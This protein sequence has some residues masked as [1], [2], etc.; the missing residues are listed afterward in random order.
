MNKLFLQQLSLISL[1]AS[2]L[3]LAACGGSDT[4]IVERDPIAIED[5]HD[6]H[7]EH[8][9]DDDHNHDHEQ[10]LGRLLIS[11]KDV[12]RVLVLDA[13][14][15]STLAEFTTSG[16]PSAVYASPGYRYGFVVQR[17]DDRVDVI[18]GGLW[19]EDHGDHMHPYAEAPS[20]MSFHTDYAR[21][22]HFTGTDSQTAI[23]YD[24]N[25]DTSTPAAVAV[26]TEAD[27][28][29]NGTGIWLEYT[30]HQHG[31]AQARGDY[32]LSTIRDPASSS[33]LP[34]QVGL[35]HAH[36]DHFDEE[37]VFEEECPGLHGSAQNHEFI[38]FGCTDGV[39]AIEQNGDNFTARKLPNPDSFTGST[40]IGTL[41]GDE[42]LDI[43][44]G[45]A[46]GHFYA[47]IRKQKPFRRSC[48][49]KRVPALQVMV[50]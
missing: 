34:H 40:R 42:H 9:H 5:D 11:E 18:D 21:P 13:T 2:A 49:L 29:D 14:E 45:I 4:R 23:F 17:T 25:V 1:L 28:A 33:T 36:G 32:L 44:V 35:Y 20:F 30:T 26:F 41:V 6:D 50:L 8:D 48:G 3:L 31:A 43:F 7:D 27:L 12:A 10:S 38:A 24:G 47:V 46:S 39:L 19:Q 37:L 15:K 16:V 22:T